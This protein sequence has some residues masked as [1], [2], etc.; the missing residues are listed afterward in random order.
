VCADGIKK[1]E[2]CSDGPDRAVT[3]SPF[4]TNFTLPE[5]NSPYMTSSQPPAWIHLPLMQPSKTKE[6]LIKYLIPNKRN[7]RSDIP[8]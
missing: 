8:N 2:K 4:R 6:F 5:R 1:E 3:Y 7:N